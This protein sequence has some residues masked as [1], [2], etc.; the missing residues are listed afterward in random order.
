[1]SREFAA[2]NKLAA[3]GEGCEHGDAARA[4]ERGVAGRVAERGG[5]DG[6]D[7]TEGRLRQAHHHQPSAVGANAAALRRRVSSTS[8]R[9]DLSSRAGRAQA[10]A[11]AAPASGTVTSAA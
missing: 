11:L 3:S 9:R 5:R 8:D 2:A 1:M 7:A 4:S 10:A 6:C